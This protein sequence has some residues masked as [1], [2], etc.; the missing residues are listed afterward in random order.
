MSPQEYVSKEFLDQSKMTPADWHRKMAEYAVI[1]NADFPLER[2]LGLGETE[3]QALKCACKALYDKDISDY[4]NSLYLIFS[5]LSGI[6][7]A[8]VEDRHIKQVYILLS[9]K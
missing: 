4:E 3:K 5:I 1:T 9:Q 2:I 7:F 6:A 8:E